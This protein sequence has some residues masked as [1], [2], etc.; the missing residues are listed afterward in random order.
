MVHYRGGAAAIDPSVYDNVDEFW[1]D[2]S[3]AYAEE[4]RRLGELGCTTCNW[5]TPRSPISTTRRSVT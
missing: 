5:T 3:A 4:V 1:D 2:L